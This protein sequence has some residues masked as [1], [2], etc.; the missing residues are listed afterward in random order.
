[1]KELN[2]KRIEEGL[3]WLQ[4]E[5][6]S[7]GE[8]QSVDVLIQQ[9]GAIN[10]CIAWSGEQMAI[11]KKNLNLKKVGAYHALIAS[12]TANEKYFA[13]SL[14]KDYISARCHQ[15]QYE[16]DLCERFTR[17]LVHISDN[18][19]TSISALKEQMKLSQY[20]T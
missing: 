9:L 7:T 14:G 5:F 12:E 8:I 4:N 18:V 13:P 11:A 15:E 16:Y 1:M 19:R 20:S 6:E 10:S 17:S 3:N 2:I